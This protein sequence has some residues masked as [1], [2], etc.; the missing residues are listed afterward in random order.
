[1]N[2]QRYIGLKPYSINNSNLFFGRTKEVEQLISILNSEQIVVIHST[3]GTGKTSVLNAGLYPNLIKNENNKCF[4]ITFPSWTPNSLALVEQV[5]KQISVL[6]PSM[7][8]I[9]KI[10]EN[11]NSLWIQMKRIQSDLNDSITIHLLF[12][13]FENFFTYPDYQRLDFLEAFHEILYVQMPV[14]FS[15]TFRNIISVSN[16][17]L[18]K[19][20]L[21]K[22]YDPVKIKLVFSLR[23]DKIPIITGLKDKLPGIIQNIY[24]L[25]V[26][27][28]ESVKEAI[29][30]PAQFVPEQVSQN[31]F[32][33]TPF[34]YS[35]NALNEIINRLSENSTKRIELF[36][37]QLLCSDIEDIVQKQNIAIIETSHLQ[38][39]SSSEDNYYERILNLFINEPDKEKIENLIENELILEDE[40]RRLKIYEG[41][42]IKKFGISVP[43]L[44]QLVNLHIL[45]IEKTGNGEIFY[46]INHDVLVKPI[47]NAKKRRIENRIR[48]QEEAKK[49]AIIQ[50]IEIKQKNKA[51]KNKMALTF[52]SII[53]LISIIFATIAFT[54]RQN[55]ENNA[56]LSQ[57]NL[58][59]AYSF[60]H[61][62]TDP[63]ISFRL[64]QEAYRLDKNNSSAYSALL[65][66][67]YNTNIFY[68]ITGYINNKVVSASFASDG[69]VITTIIRDKLNENYAVQIIDHTG[70]IIH[71][72]PHPKEI[73]SVKISE[74]N[75]YILTTC[76]DSI[77]RIWDKNGHLLL[78]ITNHKALL[79]YGA[80]SED[81]QLIATAGSDSKVML[82][83]LKGK[84]ITDFTSHDGDIYSVKFSKSGKHILT[85]GSDNVA[86]LWNTEGKLI[87]EFQIIEDKRFS[88]SMI[89][90]ADFSSDENFILTASND[91]LNKNH[92]AIVWDTEGNE[93]MSFKG[94]D[95][96]INDATFSSDSKYIITTSRDKTVRVWDLSGKQVKV[97]KGHNS[98]V[99]SA[100]FLDDNQRIIT[101]G[102]D[103]TIRVWSIGRQFDTYK[104][105]QNISF[106]RFSPDGLNILSVKNSNAL[107]W[108]LLG[109][110]LATLKGHTGN[111]STAHY[112]PDGKMIVT[113]SNDKSACV[114]DLSGKLL[115]C[116][117]GH[118]GSVKTAV[119]STDS[120][121][122]LTASEDSTARLWDLNSKQLAIFKG[123]KGFVQT[124]V[125]SPDGKMVLTSGTDSVAILWKIS[126][127]IIQIFKGHTDAL[128]SA[129]FSPSGNEIITTSSDETAVLWSVKGVR[130]HIFRGYENKVNSAEFS[131]NGQ[132][133]VTTSD[134]GT[135][136]MW[137]LKGNEIMVFK[138]E[139][140]VTSASFSPDG[141][142][143]ISVYNNGQGTRTFKIWMINSDDVIRYIDDLDLYGKVWKPDSGML[144]S[145]DIG[146][147]N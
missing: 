133:I 32:E 82:W 118:K 14:R 57:A 98:N 21:K 25:P 112:S 130:L 4:I 70:K 35:E 11:D 48:Q 53:A 107:I 141:N 12:D 91:Y 134:D 58:L 55:S 125:F 77:A 74:K 124:A 62:E 56:L 143:I 63:T 8:F 99:W 108:D 64:A 3:P 105:A 145:Y 96:W 115:W 5:K 1:M 47:L 7:S 147:F 94:H 76:S 101:V 13:Q 52:S 24:E 86:R 10:F 38:Q 37:L 102:D 131:P 44:E 54:L 85:S 137:N 17:I 84:K 66:S 129:V 142:Y 68:S 140:S 29:V 100:T 39:I 121:T 27:S 97:L 33:T 117:K 15:E 109:E 72:L 110:N 127:E 75:T 113:A 2:Q 111:V 31:K 123:H 83:N 18:T 116:I 106:A 28:V 135:A 42:V 120:K 87:K 36:E 45:N 144:K 89:L 26:L 19:D 43:V 49:I 126:G 92:Q 61:L 73:T 59:A 132:Y 88:K 6:E 119:F 50:E 81:H 67:F 104:N 146:K 79:W 34:T 93:L 95:E 103:K 69:K 122:L 9:D 114:W 20:G 41:V 71:E 138:H 78:A 16:S 40:N 22:L 80:I 30:K 60:Q 51:R 90:T 136:R 128:T 139:G 46:E 65:N 23:S